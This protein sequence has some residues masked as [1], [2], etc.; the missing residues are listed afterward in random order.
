MPQTVIERIIGTIKKTGTGADLLQDDD[1]RK[2][3]LGG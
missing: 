2:A 3:Y 1:V